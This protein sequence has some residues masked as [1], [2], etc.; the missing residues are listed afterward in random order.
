M[1]VQ[2]PPIDIENFD[3]LR[4][5]LI[6]RGLADQDEAVAFEHLTGGVS[7][8][9]VLVKRAG[10]KHWVMKQA[11]DK[12]RVKADW[13]S[14][15]ARIH[16]EALALQWLPTITP[17]GVTPALIFEDE[18]LH[19]LAME[20]IPLPHDN[21]KTLLLNGTV[22]MDHVLQF[23]TILHTLHAESAKQKATLH[24][25]FSE[26][27]YFESLRLEPYYAYTAEKNPS[28]Q[29]FYDH[30]IGETRGIETTLVHGD[31]SPKNILVHNQRLILLDHEVIHFGDPAFDIGF[32]LTHLL[33]KAHH[34]PHHRQQFA[35][36]AHLYWLTYWQAVIE[37]EWAAQ[38][39][40]RAVNHTLGCLLA[41]IDGRS[42]LEYLTESER[43]VQRNVTLNLIQN[44]PN[45]VDNL[46]DQFT[47][48]L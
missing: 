22:D 10:G 17:N 28:A 32:S 31:Y 39:E 7:N 43:D 8:R 44:M 35:A 1:S 37:M 5:Y 30:L 48:S 26:R 38:L 6:D 13:H 27:G 14:N 47:E 19:I 36:A 34:L 41:R 25:I 46:I 2:S 45:S 11:L 23:A 18:S 3:D 21:W 29:P 33:S 9:T 16:Q 12:L 24:P 15:P 42:P 40:V 4:R 20:A